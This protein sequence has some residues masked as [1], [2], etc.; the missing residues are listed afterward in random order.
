MSKI[1]QLKELTSEQQDGLW[2]NNQCPICES[3][4]LNKWMTN[5]EIQWVCHRDDIIFLEKF[6]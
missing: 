4:L 6:Y 2:I 1:V 5:I 3:I